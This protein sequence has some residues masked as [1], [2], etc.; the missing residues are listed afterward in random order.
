MNTPATSPLM[1]DELTLFYGKGCEIGAIFVNNGKRFA[2]LVFNLEYETG[3]GQVVTNLNVQFYWILE[4]TG[5]FL[6]PVTGQILEM[7]EKGFPLPHKILESC[8]PDEIL[9]CCAGNDHQDKIKLTK[10]P[11]HVLALATLRP[12]DAPQEE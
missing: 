5:D 10:K 3:Q 1:E 8:R 4:V 6:E 2:G 11:S 7:T 9:T 12:T